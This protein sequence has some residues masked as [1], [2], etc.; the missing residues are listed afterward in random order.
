MI[1]LLYGARLSQS[2]F[3]G[4]IA[5]FC[6]TLKSDWWI[7]ALLSALVPDEELDNDLEDSKVFLRN[8]FTMPNWRLPRAGKITQHSQCHEICELVPD[9]LVH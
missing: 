4:T 9:G 7:K 8:G 3:F 6:C 5:V 2:S 1:F